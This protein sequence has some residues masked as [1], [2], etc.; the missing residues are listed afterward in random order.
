M[1][2]NTAVRIPDFGHTED[3]AITV[4]VD[5]RADLIAGSTDTIRAFTDKPLLAEH[6]FA[7]LVDLKQAGVRILWD[8]GFTGIALSE[9]L[10]RMEIEA[11]SIDLIALSHGHSDHTGAVSAILRAMA[12]RTEPRDWPPDVPDEEL[13]QYAAGRQ[14]PIVAHSAAFREGWKKRKGGGW[15]GPFHPPPRAE[16]EALGAELLLSDGPHR[17]GP[18]CWT[19]GEVPRDSFERS[20]IPKRLYYRE[21]GVFAPDYAVDDQSM[22]INLQGKGLIV[23]SGCAHSGIVNTVEHAREISGVERVWAVI[24]GYHLAQAGEEEVEQT[25]AEFRRFDPVLVAPAHCT[26]FVATRRFSLEFPEA[27]DLCAVGRTYLL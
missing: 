20:G 17:L 21:G 15:Q 24:G 27:F 6:G 10:A 22:V 18:G 2:T 26:G 4:L 7:A 3:V 8:A 13:I 16:W 11:G 12:L 5:N 1:R 25:I 9:N 14:V 23:L 19:T